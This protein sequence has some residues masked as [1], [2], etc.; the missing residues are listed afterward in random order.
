MSRSL[1]GCENLKACHLDN[2]IS[3]EDSGELYNFAAEDDRIVGWF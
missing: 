1:G 3:L 2:A